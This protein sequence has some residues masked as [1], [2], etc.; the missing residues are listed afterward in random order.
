[1][2]KLDLQ[3]SYIYGPI[4]SRR[5]GVSL[6]INLSPTKYKLCSFDCLYC[7]YGF[8]DIKTLKYSDS[9]DV[10]TQKEVID[11]LRAVLKQAEQQSFKFDYIT[12]AGNGEPTVHPEF[13]GIAEEIITVRD[14]MIPAAKIAVLSNA[15]CITNQKVKKILSRLD[16]A[17]I[18]LDAGDENMFQKIN[19]PDPQVKFLD[20]LSGLKSLDNVTLQTLFVE[21][22]AVNSSDEH[23]DKLIDCYNLIQPRMVQ[24]YS[25]DRAP[26]EPLLLKV[27]KE[28]LNEI[29]KRISAKLPGLNVAVY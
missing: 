20:V 6:G 28:R 2:K 4:N 19:R 23:V 10:P 9:A 25:L 24:I 21:G 14:E 5:L 27:S 22:I 1:M 7:Q 29:R 8:T 17:I 11:E 15:S 16:D 26:A 13:C 18:K 12:F 3:S